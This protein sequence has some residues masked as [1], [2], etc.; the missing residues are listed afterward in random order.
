MEDRI[1]RV[2]DSKLTQ[3][4]LWPSVYGSMVT[5]ESRME[6]IAWIAVCRFN[7]RLEGGFVRDWVVA[8]ERVRPPPTIQTSEWVKFDT[9]TGNPFLLEELV[10]SDLD[11][12]LPSNCYFDLENFCDEVKQFEMIPQIYRYTSSYRLLFDQ[13]HPT[14]PFL[15]DLFEPYKNVR[16]NIPDLDVNNLCIERDQCTTLSQC[17]DLIEPS[18]SLHL[19]QTVESI[20]RKEFHVLAS[21]NEGIVKRINKM[22]TR[23]WTQIGSTLIGQPQIIKPKLVINPLPTDSEL[24]KYIENAIQQIIGIKIIS[25]EEAHNS[26]LECIYQSMKKLIA[27]HCFDNN[28]NEKYL[29]HGVHTDKSRNIIREGFDYGFFQTNGSFG[30][31]KAFHFP[32]ISL[33]IFLHR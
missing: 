24:Y 27:D 29:F 7:C 23:G 16:F 2:A 5:R 10:P 31:I 20:K 12:K 22:T 19:T 15:L 3:A 30:K 25:I 1:A 33:N 13:Y 18:Y 6:V 8:N 11:C 14:G 28:T 32:N 9:K 4:D 17:V 26:E 21:I